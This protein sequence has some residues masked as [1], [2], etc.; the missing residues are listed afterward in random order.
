MILELVDIRIQPG[1]QAEFQT[2]LQ[3]G[4]TVLIPAFAFGRTQVL[5]AMI[6]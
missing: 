2:A 3:R 6:R 5:L 4:G 1:K